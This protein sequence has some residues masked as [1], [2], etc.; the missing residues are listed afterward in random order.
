MK[1]KRKIEKKKE[2]QKREKRKKKKVSL[3]FREV[4]VNAYSS[5]I[6]L[7]SEFLGYLNGLINVVCHCVSQLFVSSQINLD[8]QVLLWLVIEINGCNALNIEVA[9]GIRE[10]VMS[11]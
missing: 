5:L 8:R 1:G 9:T 6:S 10:K 2:K 7:G 11:A 3:I 4:E